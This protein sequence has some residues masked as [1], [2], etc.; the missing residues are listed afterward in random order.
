MFAIASGVA[1]AH[2]LIPGGQSPAPITAAREVVSASNPVTG[3]AATVSYRQVTWGTSIDVKVTGVAP[4]VSCT[5]WAVNA[6]GKRFP[7]G[8][9]RVP[10]GTG[11]AEYPASSALQEQDVVGFQIWSGGQDLLNIPTT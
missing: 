10:Y 11:E 7:A 1:G 4:G 3:V 2:F 5:M 8:S 9:W 6:D